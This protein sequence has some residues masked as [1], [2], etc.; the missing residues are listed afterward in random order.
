MNRLEII[1]V[2]KAIERLA[3]NKDLDGIKEIAEAVLREVQ[4]KPA[5]TQMSMMT[6]RFDI[7]SL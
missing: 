5:L 4:A 2:F 7:H 6:D 1:A 3:H